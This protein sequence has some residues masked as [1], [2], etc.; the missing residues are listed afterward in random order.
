MLRGALSA[1]GRALPRHVQ[2]DLEGFL[3]CGDPVNGFASLHCAGCD[4]HRLVNLACTGRGFCP[5]C[6][7]RRI[8]ATSAWWIDRVLPHVATRQ[9][10]MTVP[11]KHRW[12]LARRPKLA[13]GVHTIA[14]WTIKRWYAAAGGAPKT[15]RTGA[16][17]ATKRFSSAF[18]LK[19]EFHCIFLDGIYTRGAGDRLSFRRVVPHTEDIERLVVRIAGACGAWQ[20][21]GAE[22]EGD[23][24]GDDDA[25]AVIQQASLRGQTAFGEGGRRPEGVKTRD[26][27]RS[28]AP[29]PSNA[30]IP[31]ASNV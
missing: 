31:P 5:R 17:T 14:P 1:V 28:R 29:R 27:G 20:G 24:E 13:S 8:A 10:V 22:D 15:G 7:G 3:G 25:Q 2:E 19:L 12:L 26:R 4:P 9:S 21:F 30:A 11:W 16:V 18:N 23:D 6:G